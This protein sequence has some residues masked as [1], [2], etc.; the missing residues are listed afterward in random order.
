MSMSNVVHSTRLLVERII[1]FFEANELVVKR[2]TF[3]RF[4]FITKTI[5]E[6]TPHRPEV[7]ETVVRTAYAMSTHGKQRKRP[8]EDIL[9]SSE[10]AR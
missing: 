8:I 2:D 3:E 10:T 6:R 9:G 1:S 7:F 4:A 5:P